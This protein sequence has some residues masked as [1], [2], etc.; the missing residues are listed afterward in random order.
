MDLTKKNLI[1]INNHSFHVELT[2][3]LEILKEIW[4]S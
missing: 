3:Q 1:D 2:I 4:N